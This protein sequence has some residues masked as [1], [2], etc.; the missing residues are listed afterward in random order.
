[1]EKKERRE[2]EKTER[3]EKR[4]RKEVEKKERKGKGKEKKGRYK[5]RPVPSTRKG[6]IKGFAAA[7]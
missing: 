6:R 7:P 1:M 2:M 3:K 5:A 4:E